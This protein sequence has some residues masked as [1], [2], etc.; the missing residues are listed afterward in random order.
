MSKKIISRMKTL[1]FWLICV[2]VLILPLFITTY[3]LL[4]P[5]VVVVIYAVYRSVKKEK[6]ERA[7]CE[8]GIDIESV[9][10]QHPNLTNHVHLKTD[11]HRSRKN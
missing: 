4:L 1:V 6:Q 7:D 9:A 2:A 8:R 10:Y 3:W 5:L 11:R